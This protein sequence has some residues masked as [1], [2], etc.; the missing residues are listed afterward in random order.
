MNN[1]SSESIIRDQPI[2]T[3]GFAMV[4]LGGA[5]FAYLRNS[6]QWIFAAV[7]A[8]VGLLLLAVP[9]LEIKA[10][11]PTNTLLIYRRSLYRRSV[12]QIKI[13]DIVNI[14]VGQKYD[15][16]DDRRSYR[17]EFHLKNG[18]MVPLRK[19]YS[20]GNKRHKEL[21]QKL[22]VICG[23]TAT[24]SNFSDMFRSEEI[25]LEFQQE[26]EEITGEQGGVQTTDGV[27]W[28]FET[29]VFGS[30]PISHWHSPDFRLE[31][32]FIY[33]AQKLVGQKELP[34]LLK[35]ATGML[36]KQSMRVYGIDEGDTPD[37]ASAESIELPDRLRQNYLG[38]SDEGVR[39]TSMLNS[40]VIT[41]LTAWA[42]NHPM[43][44][45]N[46]NS[47]L[48]VHIGP[49]G[50]SLRTPGLVNAEYLDDLTTL[51]V[52]MVRALGGGA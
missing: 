50:F 17:V 19:T 2:M 11:R 16:D 44:K 35:S 13:G 25:R 36:F 3:W 45:E 27:Q 6:N 8:V 30:M 51:G 15:R 40:W 7:L 18:G 24:S 1:T 33:L 5:V 43:T 31:D 21:A 42:E 12:Q 29:L 52:E 20:G 39:A 28:T 49:N 37:L 14:K 9:A 4:M 41:P 23:V 46:I 47:Q 34:G 48:V 32:T 38:Y 10:N 26:Q 22:G